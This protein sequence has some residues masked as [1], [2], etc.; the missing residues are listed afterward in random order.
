VFLEACY[1]KKRQNLSTPNKTQGTFLWKNFYG[2]RFWTELHKN[3]FFCEDYNGKKFFAR[4]FLKIYVRRSS[5][6]RQR[7][8]MCH[9]C[10]KIGIIFAQVNRTSKMIYKKVSFCA[11]ALRCA[12][13]SQ[14]VNFA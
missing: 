10:E 2:M 7:G 14:K 4:K 13:M 5:C 9:F 11:C 1:I 12:K 8:K 6:E 3:I